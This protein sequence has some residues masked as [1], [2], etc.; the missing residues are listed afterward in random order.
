VIEF[1]EWAN[2]PDSVFETNDFGCRPIHENMSPEICPKQLQASFRI[3]VLFRDLTL[4]TDEALTRAFSNCVLKELQAVDQTFREAVWSCNTWL[5]EFTDLSSAGLKATGVCF[6]FIGW[7]FGDTPAEAYGNA[8]RAL[9]N[10]QR[11]LEAAA[12]TV[13]PAAP[14][15]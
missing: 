2:G 5:H 11:A 10:L 9:R 7:A 14:A 13:L 15:S 12:K 6:S 4:N 3:T 1:I 8:D